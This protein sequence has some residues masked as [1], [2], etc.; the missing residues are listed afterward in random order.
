LKQLLDGDKPGDLLGSGTWLLAEKTA[1][2]KK[3]SRSGPYSD[4]PI[5]T[6]LAGENAKRESVKSHPS[7]ASR[8]YESCPQ[9]NQLTHYVSLDFPILASFDR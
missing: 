2:H 4:E 7:I 9:T 6:L 1:V 5:A 8:T 3:P